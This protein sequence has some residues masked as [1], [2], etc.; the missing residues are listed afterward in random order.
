MIAGIIA[1]ENSDLS[2][3]SFNASALF[4][5]HGNLVSQ[6]SVSTS[7]L[8]FAKFPGAGQ[9][10]SNAD[11][12]KNVRAKFTGSGLFKASVQIPNLNALL[13]GIGNLAVNVASDHVAVI[14][15]GAGTLTATM[16]GPLRST[17]LLPGV[18]ALRSAGT[19]PPFIINVGTLQSSSNT[20]SSNQS[21]PGGL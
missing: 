19:N 14:L 18:G 9:L 3:H 1:S 4:D 11:S 16:A 12:I 13:P 7:N 17:A 8:A 21:F 2:A 10:V 20:T 15:P 6:S 5:G